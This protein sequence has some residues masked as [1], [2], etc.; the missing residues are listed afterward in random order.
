MWFEISAYWA[1]ATKAGNGGSNPSGIIPKIWKTVILSSFMFIVSWWVGARK[2]MFTHGA[3]HWLATNS[4]FTMNVTA[5]LQ[6]KAEMGAT[7][8]SWN[9]WKR[10]RGECN[11]TWNL[12]V[13]QHMLFCYKWRFLYIFEDLNA[14]PGLDWARHIQKQYLLCVVSVGVDFRNYNQRNV[15]ICSITFSEF[16]QTKWWTAGFRLQILTYNIFSDA[17][18]WAILDIWSIFSQTSKKV[19]VFQS[20]NSLEELQKRFSI[21]RNKDFCGLV[22]L[23]VGDFFLKI[24]TC[25]KTHI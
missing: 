5:W 2:K 21:Q 10:L 20:R 9:S 8:H 1:C 3:I 14:F 7:D 17:H 13:T 22:K 23:F 12:S 19:T 25:V 24:N 4:V 11:W 15:Y 18:E 6:A 16:S